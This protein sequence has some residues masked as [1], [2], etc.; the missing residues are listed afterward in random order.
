M[1][2]ASVLKEMNQLKEAWRKQNLSFNTEQK[3]RY[4]ELLQ[5]RRD[6]VSQ[7]QRDG[8]VW[9]KPSAAALKKEAEAKAAAAKAA[10]EL[11]DS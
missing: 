6:R 3:R 7:L 4:E 1:K 8:Q 2:S 10:E 11:E 5:L 9:V